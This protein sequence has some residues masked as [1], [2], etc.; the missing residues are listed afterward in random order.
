[1]STLLYF[2][3]KKKIAY[4]YCENCN[5]EGKMMIQKMGTNFYGDFS[6]DCVYCKGKKYIEIKIKDKK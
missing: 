5:H 6:G 1:M 2:D 3:K 4:L